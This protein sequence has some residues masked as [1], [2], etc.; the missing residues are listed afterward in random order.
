MRSMKPMNWGFKKKSVIAI[1][2]VLVMLVAVL[3]SILVP[4]SKSKTAEGDVFTPMPA[5]TSETVE[6]LKDLPQVLLLI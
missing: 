1:I 5:Q 3:T 4:L 6:M 2:L